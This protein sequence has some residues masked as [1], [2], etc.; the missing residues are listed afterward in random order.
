MIK[1]R[2]WELAVYQN[3]PALSQKMGGKREAKMPSGN[4]DFHEKVGIVRHQSV[5]FEDSPPWR[6]H[7]ISNGEPMESSMKR[8]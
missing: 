7:A 3:L 8:Y 1:V 5:T 4:A 6:A 2:F